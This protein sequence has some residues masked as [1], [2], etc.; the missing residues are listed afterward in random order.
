MACDPGAA[1]REGLSRDAKE[2]PA[3]HP[4]YIPA[5][6]DGRLHRLHQEALRIWIGNLLAAENRH[7]CI[8]V[9]RTFSWSFRWTGVHEIL[10][11]DDDHFV[12]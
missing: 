4:K 11:L 12:A 2:R 9:D 1:Q 3:G 8:T 10:G 7:I 5:G 6:H